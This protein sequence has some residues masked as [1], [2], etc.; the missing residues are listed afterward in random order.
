M[1]QFLHGQGVKTAKIAA[2]IKSR[3]GIEAVLKQA[4]KHKDLREKVQAYRGED[5]R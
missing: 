1:I 5:A 4:V 3:G 2:E